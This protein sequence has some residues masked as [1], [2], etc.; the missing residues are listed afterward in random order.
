MTRHILTL[1]ASLAYAATAS[2]AAI[3]P[4]Q[5]GG[6]ATPTGCPGYSARN[7][8]TTATGLT[9][10]LSLAGEACNAYGTDIEELRLSVNYDAATRL[11]V[12]IEDAA[13]VAYQVPTSV[14][15]TPD[16]SHSVSAE[17]SELEFRH[18]ESPFSFSVVRRSNGEVLFDSSAAPLIFEDQYLR[19]RTSLPEDPNL[20]GLGEHSDSLRFNTTDYT[21][22]I[23]SRDSYG[24]PS[25]TNLYGEYTL[26]GDLL[27]GLGDTRYSRW[28]VRSDSQPSGEEPLRNCRRLLRISAF[29][30]N[31]Q[32]KLLVLTFDRQ[33][34]HL[35][36]APRRCRHPRRL[37]PL[38][39]GHGRQGQQHP[40]GWAVLGVQHHGRRHRSLRHGWPQP[41]RGLEAVCRGRWHARN[42]PVLGSWV[43]VKVIMSPETSS[44]HS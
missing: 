1:T 2:A 8:H 27:S 13:G 29:S 20:Y 24:I 25:G 11:H 16:S 35:L 36:R 43:S 14:F 28:S 9:A 23:W 33:P 40:R 31:H 39:L 17:D 41:D 3:L 44:N 10:D 34:P 6:D 5:L 21:R 12:K 22:T 37:P 15:G 7:V 42:V 19:L 26:D 30:S 38:Q 32:V 18:E 4:R